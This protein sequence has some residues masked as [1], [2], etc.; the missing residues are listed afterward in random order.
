MT[1]WDVVVVGAGPAGAV[2]AAQFA[3]RGFRVALLDRAHFPRHKACAEFM[4]PGVRDVAQRLG[5]WDAIQRAGPCSVPG[6]EIVSPSGTVLRLEYSL[7]GRRHYAATLPRHVLDDKLVAHAE[8]SGA[9]MISGVIAHEPIMHGSMVSGVRASRAGTTSAF[10]AKLTVVA[11]GNRSTIARALNLTVP[12]CW[13]VRMG[14]V[15]HYEGNAPLRCGFGQMHV[16]TDGYCGVAPLPGGRLNVAVVVKAD[17]VRSSGMS[18]FAFFE[19]WIQ[20]KPAL[21]ELLDACTRVSPV[22]GICPIGSRVSRVSTGGAMLVGDAAGFFDPFT[23]E[24]IYRALRGAEL[25]AEVGRGALVR[26]D[27]SSTELSRYDS[28]RSAA[29]ARKHAVTALVQLFVQFPILMQY[30][31]PRLT[32]RP[33]PLQALSSVLGDCRD[34]RVFLNVPT[35]WSALRP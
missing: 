2:S 25:V 7:D 10:S 32:R 16:G 12:A 9:T 23:G 3:K 31:L 33:E 18:A 6:M 15:A 29:F 17:V 20:R 24:G 1:E 21:C 27:V 14:L 34:A 30:A 4:S 13:P 11:D 28:L 19:R 35:L 5:L 8:A 22:R 26:G